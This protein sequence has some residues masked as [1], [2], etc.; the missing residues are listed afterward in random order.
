M[1]KQAIITA[2][3]FGARL[4]PHTETTPKP[5]IP[6]LGKPMLQ[7]RLEQFRKFGVTEFFFTLSYLPDA[8]TNYFGD[9]SKFG[10]KINYFLES[11][12]LGTAGALRKIEDQL[13][14][15]FFYGYGD[16]IAGIDYEKMEAEYAGKADAIGMQHTQTSDDYSDADVV[17][18]DG[19]GKYIAIHP[20]PHAEK[21]PNPVARMQ[22]TFILDKK[23]LTYIPVDKPSNFGNEV[24]PS[25]LAG[26]EHFYAYESDEYVAWIDTEEGWKKVE[27]EM[28]KRL[29][30]SD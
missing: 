2:G 12:P 28:R 10:V 5:M 23:I 30:I 6:V 8:V 14:P 22:G 18:L 19:S 27:E 11:E 15:I 29:A 26:G 7:W 4:R 21:Y 13:D 25:V 20:K 3:G 9:G 16:V 1:I 24:I 17:E